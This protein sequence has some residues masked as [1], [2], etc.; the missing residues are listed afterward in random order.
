MKL[1]IFFCFLFLQKNCLAQHADSLSNKT[2][3]EEVNAQIELKQL[4][5]IKTPLSKK[6]DS[7]IAIRDSL[8]SHLSPLNKIEIRLL[9]VRLDSLLNKEVEID[10]TFIKRHAN[11][12]SALD[13]LFYRSLKQPEIPVHALLNLFNSLPRGLQKSKKGRK[14]KIILDRN[15][16]N[17]VGHEAPY[18]HFIDVKGE[19]INNWEFLNFKYVLLDFWASWCQPCREEFPQLEKIYKKYNKELEVINISVDKDT[20]AYYKAIMKMGINNW[21]N[22]LINGQ[23][24]DSFY[25]PAIPMKYLVNKD[26]Q[27][28]G[29]WR[30]GGKENQIS[31]E[32]ILRSKFN[33]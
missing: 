4:Q 22:G 27:I 16:R 12:L 26:G 10:T 24:G 9:S 18:F 31:L 8:Q 7:I 32:N 29:R 33:F 25:I 3:E 21:P 20:A 28:I 1:F 5:I 19:N 14:L 30:G 17:Q 2:Y 13:I 15:E 6:M 11:S 23:F